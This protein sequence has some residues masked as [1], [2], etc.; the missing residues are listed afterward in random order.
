MNGFITIVDV[1]GPGCCCFVAPCGARSFNQAVKEEIYRRVF[2]WGHNCMAGVL[3][4]KENVFL[5]A[6]VVLFE[7]S[8]YASLWSCHSSCRLLCPPVRLMHPLAPTHITML[9]IPS[10]TTLTNTDTQHLTHFILN[11]RPAQTIFHHT[12]AIYEMGNKTGLLKLFIAFFFFFYISAS[13][14]VLLE[15]FLHAYNEKACRYNRGMRCSLS[16]SE[17]PPCKSYWY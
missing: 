7:V 2:I 4:K 3:Y 15:N 8:L 6:L 12:H 16:N 17:V 14:P 11:T 1:P 13:G 10:K 9:L 5:V